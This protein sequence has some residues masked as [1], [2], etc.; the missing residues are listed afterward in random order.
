MEQESHIVSKIAALNGRKLGKRPRF[1]KNP[2]APTFSQVDPVMVRKIVAS[3]L[4]RIK[5]GDLI[6][7][8]ESQSYG[9]VVFVVLVGLAFCLPILLALFRFYRVRNQKTS[10]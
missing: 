8:S 3:N 1:L 10:K 4:A 2:S 5:S 7:K 6:I 9:K